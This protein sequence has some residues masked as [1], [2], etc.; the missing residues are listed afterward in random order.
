MVSDGPGKKTILRPTTEQ[1]ERLEP[2]PRILLWALLGAVLIGVMGLGIRS[3]IWRESSTQSLPGTASAPLPVYGSVPDFA[4]IDQNGRP[5]R[6]VDLEGKI[7]IANFIFTHCPDECPLMTAEMAQLQ[8]DLA[9]VP[10]LCLVSVTV[11]PERDT[12]AVLAEYAERFHANPDRWLFLTGDK[13]AIYRLVREGFRLGIVDPTEQPHPLPTKGN[14]LSSSRNS[15]D[16][17]LPESRARAFGWGQSFLS[18]WRHLQP[19]PAFADHGR[20][21]DTLHSTRF[22][23]VDQGAQIRGYYDSREETAL[24]RLRRHLQLLRRKT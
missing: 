1:G 14:A 23:L 24:Q 11:D 10:Q 19:S 8:A 17:R 13:A 20:E 4:L 22:V 16:W 5:V 12:S 15:P 7:W 2:L 18:W 6:K 9:D 3:L 21:Q